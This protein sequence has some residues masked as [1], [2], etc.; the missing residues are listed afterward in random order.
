MAAAIGA[1]GPS[2][3]RERRG[4]EGEHTTDVAKTDRSGQPDEEVVEQDV[5]R[6]DDADQDRR[7]VH[8]PCLSHQLPFSPFTQEDARTL[9]LQPPLD[10]LEVGVRRQARGEHLEVVA[11]QPSDVGV[12]TK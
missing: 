4:K 3:A 2:S 10:A 7:D 1:V 6:C 12:L 11:R 9:S 5:D 8:Q